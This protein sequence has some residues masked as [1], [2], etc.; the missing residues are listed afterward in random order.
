MGDGTFYPHAKEKNIRS[1]GNIPTGN[2]VFDSWKIINYKEIK[3]REI[4]M[5]DEY[6][7]GSC[8]IS[9][10]FQGGLL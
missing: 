5:G 7:H 1:V 6:F 10:H 4:K 3:I 8:E 2:N 9:L